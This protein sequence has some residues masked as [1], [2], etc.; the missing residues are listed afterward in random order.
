MLGLL[1]P[2]AFDVGGGARQDSLAQVG[3]P[4]L[5]RFDFSPRLGELGI[6]C[7]WFGVAD[8]QNAAA[9]SELW[10]RT[11]R[12][13]SASEGATE[14]VTRSSQYCGC[15]RE[16]GRVSSVMSCNA[17]SNTA[18]TFD[19][20]GIRSSSG[21]STT[22]D[23]F[24]PAEPG[25][26][27]GSRE[28]FRISSR[29]A[30]TSSPYPGLAFGK[31]HSLH[32]L[33][34]HD[35]GE[36]L[37]RCQPV[38][39]QHGIR[40]CRH[41][42][43]IPRRL[44]LR[45]SLPAWFGRGWNPRRASPAG[46]PLIDQ[47]SYVVLVDFNRLERKVILWSSRS[48]VIRATRSLGRSPFRSC[49]WPDRSRAAHVK[50]RPARCTQLH[51]TRTFSDPASATCSYFRCA[52]ASS[53]RAAAVA[54]ATQVLVQIRCR[55]LPSGSNSRAQ[56]VRFLRVGPIL[57]ARHRQATDRRPTRRHPI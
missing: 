22:S 23:N 32:A 38:G 4:G 10:L 17:P 41:A 24:Q 54:A 30:V 20:A 43:Q 16:T 35:P 40:R 26:V 8:G 39:E 14:K 51:F 55:P 28:L 56:A 53:L 42:L 33:G 45:E 29:Y 34:G 21:R 25:F 12:S 3:K 36:A 48:K 47:S 7:R 11:S 1:V 37:V 18:I 46:R 2:V 49:G 9:G 31:P 13:G 44:V 57:V 19:P 15:S 6:L 5:D 27:S 50:L 52:P